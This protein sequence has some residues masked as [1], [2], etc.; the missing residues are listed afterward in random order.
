[1][2]YED[3]AKNLKGV[4]G[5]GNFAPEYLQAIFDTIKNNE[6]ILPD[7]HDNKHA[8]DYAWK[9]M[10]QN[11]SSAGNLHIC[12]TNIYDAQMFAATWKPIIATLSYVFMSATDDAVFSRVVTGFDQC[13][14]IAA[15]YGLTEC[16]DQIIKCLSIISTLATK[17]PP[18]TSLNTEIQ[19]NG[20]SVMVSELAVKFG[21]D[22]K[23]QLATVVLFRVVTGNEAIL[24]EGWR[25][26][27]RTWLNLFINSLIPPFFSAEQSESDIPPIPL[28]MPS[29]VIDRNQTNKETGLL[30]TLSSYLSSYANDDPPEPS[31]E[32]L[33]STLCAVDCVNECY[34]W[35]IFHNI[36]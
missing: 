22:Y 20:N 31:D 36:T 15:K 6:I 7:E 10:L 16:L 25:Q 4:N 2:K 26:V 5:G 24:K 29:V 13:A 23:A 1:M 8:F 14:R 18:S 21:R 12:H 35:D 33:E 30:S 3:F 17:N 19:V 11:S 28:Q 34:L 32:E 9:E 27:V